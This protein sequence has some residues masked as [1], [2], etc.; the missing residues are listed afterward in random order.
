MVE[1]L[2][3]A[4]AL[5][6]LGG[7][8][9][10]QLL[11]VYSDA[12]DALQRRNHKNVEG[13]FDLFSA[14]Q[15]EQQENSNLVLDYPDIPELSGFEMLAMEKEM[16]GLYLS[17]HPLDRFRQQAQNLK[18][19]KISAINDAVEEGNSS[20]Y[21]DGKIVTLL[22]LIS[23]KT[24]KLTR[25][26]TRMGFI[27]FEDET[28]EIELVV[29]SNIYEANIHKLH[30]GAVLGVVGEISIKESRETAE[31]EEQK[32]EP[33]ILVKSIFDPSTVTTSK[34]PAD[35]KAPENPGAKKVKFSLSS[36]ANSANVRKDNVPV[37]NAD[38]N[39]AVRSDV[40]KDLY[41]KVPNDKCREF[42]MVKSLLEIYNYGKTE[43]F[44][45]FEESKKLC[46]ALDTH[47]EI[48]ETFL[49]HM[50]HILGEANV[51]FK[52]KK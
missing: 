10:S 27:N 44:I 47:T 6:G 23:A 34:S 33:K 16:T 41:L 7:R 39:V 43:V 35:A 45:Y 29:F 17:G 9:R 3:K 32:D 14:V 52:E 20:K 40:Q 5:D 48:T 26:D 30:P 12:I 51:K 2:I 42:E 50:K 21:K 18:C 24:E 1:S 36:I 15:E 22:G 49:G 4:G 8:K 31:G 46:K 11:S 38:R 13:Q 19:D 28:A 25:N 37:V